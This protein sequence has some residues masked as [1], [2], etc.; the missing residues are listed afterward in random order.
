MLL[1][2][3]GKLYN[4]E[5]K[6]LLQKL[7]EFTLVFIVQLDKYRFNKISKRARLMYDTN[8]KKFHKKHLSSQH[9]Q[10]KNINA[11]QINRDQRRSNI[12]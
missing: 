2:K 9:F 10:E 8:R 11:M 12:I 7:K 5:S 4:K 1:M 6:I 3:V